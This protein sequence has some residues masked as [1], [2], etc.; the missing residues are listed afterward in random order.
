MKTHTSSRPPLIT[1][2]G[3]LRASGGTS[4]PSPSP[5]AST[6]RDHRS[7]QLSR[8]VMGCSVCAVRWMVGEIQSHPGNVRHSLREIFPGI[9]CVPPHTRAVP[10]SARQSANMR[11]FNGR[12]AIN[13]TEDWCDWE[14]DESKQGHT[15]DTGA[16]ATN[17]RQ[18]YRHS[19]NH[20]PRRKRACVGEALLKAKSDDE[21]TDLCFCTKR[22]SNFHSRFQI[23]VILFKEGLR[24]GAPPAQATR[25]AGRTRQGR[26]W[27]SPGVSWPRQSQLLA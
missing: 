20:E 8:V 25:P 12:T 9:R 21:D 5:S 2:A 11:A 19:A 10:V 18:P 17:H 22:R 27:S 7:T 14:G 26:D 6:G 15:P 24:T 4:P 23:R 1:T 16:C 3:R 13:D